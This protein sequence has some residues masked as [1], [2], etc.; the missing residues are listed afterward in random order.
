[1]NV[2]ILGATGTFG[3]ALTEALLTQT[4]HRLTLFSRHASDLYPE[5]SRIQAVSGD[6]LNPADLEKVLKNH[7]VVYCAISS[8]QLSVIAGHLVRLMPIYGVQRLIFV[9]AVRI[10]DE[11]PDEM[12]GKDN[13]SNNPDQ[14]PNRKPAAVIERQQPVF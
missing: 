9:A 6:A 4:K 7:D 11:I 2:L 1:M 3:T 8:D 14:I 12:D 5:N 13:V 10:Y